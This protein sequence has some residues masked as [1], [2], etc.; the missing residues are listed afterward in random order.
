MMAS[1]SENEISPAYFKQKLAGLIK[2]KIVM[3]K[4]LAMDYEH[5]LL[6]K[7]AVADWDHLSETSFVSNATS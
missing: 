4:L 6:T 3:E 7:D 2:R 1:F 5:L